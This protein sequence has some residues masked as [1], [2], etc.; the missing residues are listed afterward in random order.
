[1][2]RRC[3][4]IADDPPGTGGDTNRREGGVFIRR[5]FDELRERVMH[6]GTGIRRDLAHDTKVLNLVIRIGTDMAWASYDRQYPVYD[7][8]ALAGPGLLRE[9]RFFERHDGRWLIALQRMGVAAT[10]MHAIFAGFELNAYFGWH[11]GRPLSRA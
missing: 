7:V 1:L 5:G 6:P 3:R 2:N 11:R 9:I 8:S 10:A 4:P